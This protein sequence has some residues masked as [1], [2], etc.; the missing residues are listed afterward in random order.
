[1][2]KILIFFLLL[3]FGLT[4]PSSV[5]AAAC[6]F[7]FN[8]DTTLSSSCEITTDTANG[9]QGCS[10]EDSTGNSAGLTLTNGMALTI[11]A[12]SVG[13]TRLVTGQI[14]IN[15]ANTR[16]IIEDPNAE[17]SFGGGAALWVTD[18]DA[19]GWSANIN[20]VFTSTAAGRRRECLMR[21][22]TNDCNDNAYSVAN[23]CYSYGQSWY[24]G[25]GQSWYYGYGQSWYYGY[26]QS[27]YYGYSQS[28]YY[29]YS[30]GQSNYSFGCF[31]AGEMVR[32][33]DGT[34]KPIE[35]IV[36]GDAV[37]SWN[38]EE[39]RS[40][41]RRVVKTFVHKNNPGGYLIINGSLK[42]TA[43]HP[44]WVHTSSSWQEA[45]TLRIGDILL[46]AQGQTLTVFS[47]EYAEG[48]PTVYNIGVEGP[49]H[50][51]FIGGILVHNKI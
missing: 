17:A 14:T 2:K 48:S 40:V 46:D 1:M 26:G 19:D 45:G 42:V 22:T 4:L 5:F 33:A 28:T 15:G 20:N 30:Y 27:W 43:N 6:T 38:I 36:I 10:T 32:M 49:E 51:F 47:I 37:I 13:S 18:A 41:V 44:M 39:N 7:N 8:S 3:G 31:L 25:Y 34:Q 35:S 11:Q 50:N 29:G 21:G 23:S 12:G 9:P 16:L 24:Y